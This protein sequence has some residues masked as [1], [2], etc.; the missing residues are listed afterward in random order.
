MLGHL[1]QAYD[2]AAAAAAPTTL[3]L[4][5]ARVVVIVLLRSEKVPIAASYFV[6]R[7]RD[8]PETSAIDPITP[9]MDYVPL[10]PKI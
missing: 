5:Q 2:T 8:F 9:T 1:L 10:C 4:S 3:T 7:V 6:A